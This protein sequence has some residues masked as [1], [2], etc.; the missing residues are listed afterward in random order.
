MTE[1]NNGK[2]FSRRLGLG[3]A[4][5]VHLDV[6][7]AVAIIKGLDLSWVDKPAM[8]ALGICLFVGGF[9]TATDLW[10]K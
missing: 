6:F 4:A 8:F 3:I 9:L 7:Y 10:K 1:N 5:L 2:K